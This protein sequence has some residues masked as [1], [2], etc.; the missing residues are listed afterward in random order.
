MQIIFDNLEN[1]FR[2]AR[3]SFSAI[4]EFAFGARV[5][6]SAAANKAENACLPFIVKTENRRRENGKS[7]AATPKS[8]PHL[9]SR[10]FNTQ[11]D[12][13]P[14]PFLSDATEQYLSFSSPLFSKRNAIIH[15]V[16][17]PAAPK[18]ARPTRPI[19]P[20]YKTII[21]YY[22]RKTTP[23]RHK[24]VSGLN[25]LNCDYTSSIIAVGAASPFLSPS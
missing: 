1:Y 20:A 10:I 14:N 2:Q 17:E 25:S 21:A 13:L 22:E 8:N 12:A 6:R 18:K 16:F 19:K 23:K 9:P 7:V 11:R 24:A 5:F 3:Y 15:T 4:A